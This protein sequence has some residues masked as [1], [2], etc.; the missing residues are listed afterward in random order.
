MG[1]AGAAFPQDS[2]AAATNPAGMV[3]LGNR[4]D[5]SLEWFQA[6]RGSTIHGNTS[7][8]SGDRDANGRESFLIPE[9]GANRMLGGDRSVGVSIFGNGGMTRYGDNPLGALAG[10]SSP[11][12]LGF[13]QGTVAPTYAMKLGER[14]SIG[15]SLN[16]VDQQFE[17]QGFEHFD[18]PAFTAYPGHVTNRGTDQAFGVGIRAGWLGRFSPG[19]ALGAAYQP[20]TRMGNFERYKGLL[21]DGGNFDVPENYV[22]GVAL[23]P[24]SS[25]TL[26]ADVQQI[27]YSDVPSLGNPANCFLA[28]NCLLGTPTGPGSGWRDVTAVKLGLAFDATPS[29]T[30][31][32]GLAHSTQP[33][34]PDQTLLNVFAPAVTTKHFTLGATWRLAQGPELTLSFV[35][36]MENTV[37][38]SNSIPA[39]VGGGEADLRMK[40]QAIGFAL[41]W[42]M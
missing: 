4:V 15:V 33:I 7:G 42:R 27:N 26:V 24:A 41:G 29:L 14:H 35:K 34:P 6:D 22:V 38:G 30:L 11:A 9:F 18:T 12:G 32:A 1:G 8:L 39:G 28:V 13:V 37:Q 31:R 20:K 10:N 40:Q 3:W 25:L 5:A 23:K 2:L 36:A 16:L 17:A 19:I 21:A